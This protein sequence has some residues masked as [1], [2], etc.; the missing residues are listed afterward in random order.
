MVGSAGEGGCGMGSVGGV[1]LGWGPI[2][3]KYD[4]QLNEYV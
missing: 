1:G 4:E 3:T 2:Y